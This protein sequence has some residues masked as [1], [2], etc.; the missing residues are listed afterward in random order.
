MTIRRNREETAKRIML[1]LVFA[2]ACFTRIYRIMEIPSGLNTDE[3]G[4]AY[5]AWSILNF[6]VDRNLKSWPLW[7]INYGDGQSPLY[8]YLCMLLFKLFGFRYFLIRVPAIVFSLGNVLFS[9]LIGE[10]ICKELGEKAGKIQRI[11]FPILVSFIVTISPCIIMLER[12]GIDCDLMLGASTAFIYFFIKC[13]DAKEQKIKRYIFA[14]ISGSIVFYTYTLSHLMIPLFFV[15]SFIYLLSKKKVNIK[16][17]LVMLIVMLIL[18]VP[19]ILEHA[20]N[21]FDLGDLHIG[22]FTIPE[23]TVYRVRQFYPPTISG[24]KNL[25]HYIFIGDVRVCYSI[26][27]IKNMYSLTIPLFV[28]GFV[29]LIVLVF[30][31]EKKSY[32]GVYVLFWFISVFI[33][34]TL[35]E[36]SLTRINA[37]FFSIAFI[38]AYGVYCIWKVIEYLVAKIVN[39]NAKSRIITIIMALFFVAVV[40]IYSKNFAFFAR[41]YYG[42]LYE[43]EYVWLPLFEET[44]DEAVEFLEEH[45][46]YKGTSCH[47]SCFDCI[48]ALALKMSP[49]DFAKLDENEYWHPLSTP[50]IEPGMTFI[51]SN[52]NVDY[53]NG[54]RNAGYSE[55]DFGKYTIFYWDQNE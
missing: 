15:F 50:K 41:Y 24:I 16:G 7:L 52:T 6:G 49:Y 1:L 53:M 9:Y 18:S 45:P 26:P 34:G 30:K 27:G 39:H 5:D 19:A 21:I 4:M 2:I 13:V 43:K 44:I 35:I 54:L 55:L 17:W 22:K 40:G 28:I 12:F 42:G 33:I 32:G 31:K 25:L 38:A 23:L 47:T 37:I 48:M 3:A 46:E 10:E 29:G 8:C 14:G 11:F 20:V 36:L 51:M